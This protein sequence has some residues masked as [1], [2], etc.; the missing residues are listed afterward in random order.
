METKRTNPYDWQLPVAD[1]KLFAG[2]TEELSIVGQQIS[3]MASPNPIAT[4]VVIIGERSV[5]KTS[6]IIRIS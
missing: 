3:R 5:G 2:R 6:I 4:S 1:P